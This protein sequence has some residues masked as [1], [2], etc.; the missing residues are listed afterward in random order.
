MVREANH[1]SRWM[2]ATQKADLQSLCSLTGNP[3]LLGLRDSGQ[4]VALGSRPALEGPHE[5]G[6]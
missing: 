4:N 6:L 5:E 3:G 2:L 1:K